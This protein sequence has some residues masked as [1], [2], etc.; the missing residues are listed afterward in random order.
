MQARDVD[1]RADKIVFGVDDALT[2]VIADHESSVE[3]DEGRGGVRGIYGHAPFRVQNR[4]LAVAPF[5][6][7]GITDVSPGAV[8]RPAGTVIPA[9]RVLRNI[10]ADGA[11]VSDLR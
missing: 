1:V 6:R 11:L 2:F 7:V 3:R 4:V 9:T 5:R 10:A 8:A